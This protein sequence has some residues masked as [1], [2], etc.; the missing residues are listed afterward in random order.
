MRIKQSFPCA[1]TLIVV[2]S[3]FIFH[4]N[5]YADAQSIKQ[6]ESGIQAMN[7]SGPDFNGDGFADIPVGAPGSFHAG[8]IGAG[9]VSV[10][11]GP[12]FNYSKNQ[13][14]H[15]G[16]PGIIGANERMDYWGESLSYGDFNADGFDDLVV[17]APREDIGQTVNS[18]SV[19][20]LYGS[21]SGL[22][23]ESSWGFNQASS[24]IPGVNEE[25][26][27]W[28]SALVS[29]DFNGDSYADLVIGAPYQDVGELVD[30]GSILVLFGGATGLSSLNA[31]ELSLIHI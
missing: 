20:I 21:N 10:L 16:S 9:S 29:G 14:F 3:V 30:A 25:N 24:G 12:Y 13:R 18:G 27:L 1:L 8:H 28:G 7:I 26:D 6:I 15:Q 22:R 11:Y 4:A 5:E 23:S 17:A 2:A 31:M 19:W